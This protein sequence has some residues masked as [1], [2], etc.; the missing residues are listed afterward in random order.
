MR[1]NDFD[2]Q[3]S[4]RLVD[5]FVVDIADITM[6]DNLEQHPSTIYGTTSSWKRNMNRQVLLRVYCQQA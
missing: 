1:A 4:N 5:K 2:W 6:S 3:V